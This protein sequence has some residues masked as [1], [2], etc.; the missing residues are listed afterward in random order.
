VIVTPDQAPVAA[1]AVTPGTVG[2]ATSFD[3]SASTVMY[4][5]IASYHWDFGDGTSATTATSATTHVYAAGGT[6]PVTLTETSSNGTSLTKV[7]TGQT[8]LRNGGPSA[9]ATGT[10]TIPT[11]PAPSVT[12]AKTASVDSF[13]AA[14][15]GITYTYTVTDNGNVPLDNVT[16]ADSS[17]GAVCGPAFALAVKE[18]RPCTVNYVT[19]AADVAAGQITNTVTVNVQAN[20]HD[21]EPPSAAVTLTIPLQEKPTVSIG[22]TASVPGFAAAG[23]HVTYT[24]TVTDN[25]NVPLHDVTVND[26][27]LGA[28]TCPASALAV[29]QAMTCTAAYRTTAADVRAGKV[30]NTATVNAASPGG[31]AVT[32]QAPLTIPLQVQLAVAIQKTAS[33]GSFTAAGQPVTY[34]FLVTD[35]GNVPLHAVTVIDTEAVTVRCP[36][37]TLAVGQA[38]TCTAVYRTTR[39]D[40]TGRDAEDTATV[41]AADPGGLLLT[42]QD[43][44]AIPLLTRVLPQVPVTG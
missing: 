1:L 7:Y 41:T 23:T 16:V 22:K 27:R 26:S 18:S 39:A 34:T 15:T 10:V 12:V 43:S 17:L 32:G 2:T 5:T 36:A 30:A 31:L 21:P 38:M 28:V 24:Y 9:Q 37:T 42:R 35:N 3:A 29:G 6:Y 11:A 33:A 4:G 13:A 44:L 40:V 20:A 25:G 8:M 14:G 19:T